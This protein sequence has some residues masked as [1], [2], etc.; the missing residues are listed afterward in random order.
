MNNEYK[1]LACV[2]IFSDG[3]KKTY[4]WIKEVCHTEHYI[5]LK[6]KFR[7][8]LLNR[9]FVMCMEGVEP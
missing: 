4:E 6:S 5:I 7:D 8:V 2:V 1:Y 3:T 9:D